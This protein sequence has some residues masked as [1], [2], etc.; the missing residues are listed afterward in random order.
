MNNN[1]LP[2]INKNIVITRSKD[3]ISDVKTLFQKRGANVFDLPALVVDF[4]EDLSSLDE[5]LS[6]ISHYNWVI[7][8]SSNGIKFLEKRLNEQG[9]SLKIIAQSIKIAV[10]GEKTSHSLIELGVKAD[11]VPPKFIAESL[12]ENFPISV[13][14]L[15]ILLPRVQT[16]GRNFI[17]QELVKSGANVKEVAAYESKC[18]D[19]IP[20][21]TLL[22]F[23]EKRIDAITFSS[24]KIVENTA[25][26]LKRYCGK[27]WLSNLKK[28]KLLS[29]GPQ[30]SIACQK[31]FGRVDYE[32]LTYTFEGLLESAIHSLS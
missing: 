28:V 25:F 2:L 17:S 4:P 1:H 18:P 5:S 13:D 32:A 15:K 9:T 24:G 27:E 7:F 12:I 8:S 22:A 10:V 21:E 3:K 23:K 30:T 14:G 20:A 31:T 11:F 29:I 19:N 6:S 16:G 26:L